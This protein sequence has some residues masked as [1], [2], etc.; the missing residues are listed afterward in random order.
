MKKKVFSWILGMIVAIVIFWTIVTISNSNNSKFE[1]TQPVRWD[2]NMTWKVRQGWNQSSGDN[3][4]RKNDIL[5]NNDISEKLW[6]TQEEIEKELD[7]GKTMRDLMEEKGINM[8]EMMW[9]RE[10]LNWTWFKPEFR[11]WDNH[12]WIEISQEI[13]GEVELQ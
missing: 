9:A 8:W 4:N 2:S 6:M 11:T 10:N 5:I 7:D 12:D 13:T 1:S 3:V